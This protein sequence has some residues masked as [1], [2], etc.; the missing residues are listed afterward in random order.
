MTTSPEIRASIAPRLA[1]ARSAAIALVYALGTPLLAFPAT[2]TVNA[3]RDAVDANPGDGS[4]DTR[5]I[6]EGPPQRECTLR[7]AVMESNVLAGSDTIILPAG[8]YRLTRLSASS[9]DTIGAD[10]D[11]D[12]VASLTIQGAGAASSMIDGNLCT[13]TQ[14]DCTPLNATRVVARVFR[15]VRPGATGN[16]IVQ[17]KGVTIQNAGGGAF[18]GGAV[19]VGR[20]TQ[21]IVRNTVIKRSQAGGGGGG[22]D[23]KGALSVFESEIRDNVAWSGGG[24]ISNSGTLF[25]G[26]STVDGNTSQGFG[27]G[28]ILNQGGTARIEESTISRN[29][30]TGGGTGGGGIFNNAGRLDIFDAT[31]SGNLQ[32]SGTSQGGGIYNFRGEVFVLNATVTR[33][34]AMRG[35]SDGRGGGIANEGDGGVVILANTILAGN[36]GSFGE[37]AA[38]SFR[39]PSTDCFGTFQSEGFNLLGTRTNPGTDPF[40]RKPNPP[41]TFRERPGD[42]K[43]GIDNEDLGLLDLGRRG[44][45]TET[46]GLTRNDALDPFQSDSPAVNAANPARPGGGYTCTASDQRVLT[47]LDR[48]DIGAV[49]SSVKMVGYVLSEERQ[50]AYDMTPVADGPAGTATITIKYTN[51]GTFSLAHLVAEVQ[52]IPDGDVVLNADAFR[53]RRAVGARKALPATLLLQ[54]GQSVTVQFVIGRQTTAPMSYFD[55]MVLGAPVR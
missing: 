6:T 43:V 41:C 49:E 7:A 19:S 37:A 36:F 15:I 5:P 9:S 34:A 33:N 20:N 51:A 4:C 40:T 28:G 32:R 48:C 53:R 22:I 8:L 23:N 50:T 11:L 24:G 38:Q 31:I 29:Q 17:I 52:H 14:K 21:V 3:T 46:H 1:R 47:R 45:L 18:D 26:E 30:Q 39:R 35:D 16:P 13:A 54:P 12:I 42:D 2:F 25:L 55:V 10:G 44:G 27:G